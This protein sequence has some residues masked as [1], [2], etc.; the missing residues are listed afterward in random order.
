MRVLGLYCGHD[1]SAAVV[2]DGKVLIALEE[3]RLTGTKKQGGIP[4]RAIMY[5]CQALRCS[6]WD[7]DEVCVATPNLHSGRTHAEDTN[8]VLRMYPNARLVP[9]HEA[10]AALAYVWSGFP[11][12][13]VLTLDGGGADYFG[14]VNYC[15]GGHIERV[16]SLRKDE[17]EAF[18]MLYYYV[19][20]ALGFTP[21]RHEGKVMGLAASGRDLGLFDG[22]FWV[23]GEHIRSAGKREENIVFRRLNSMVAQYTRMSSP[24]SR[25]DIAAS[26]QAAFER[27]LLQ[28]VKGNTVGKLAV[29]GGC[30]ANVLTNM[31]IA[32]LVEDFYV[33]PPMMD[34]GLSIGAALSAFLWCHVGSASL[35]ARPRHMYFGL[36]PS[37]FLWC[38]VGSASLVARPKHMYFG[39]PQEPR[40]IWKP[41]SVAKYLSRGYV[42]GLFQGAMEFGPRALGNRTILADPRDKS[43]NKTLN[44]R[45]SRTEFMPFAP[46]ILEEYAPE[47]LEDYEVGK[48][49]AP[50]MTSCWKVKEEWVSKIPAVVHVDGTA[51]PQV[52][53]RDVN[54]F[55][56]DIVK[57]FY[58]MTGIPC[59]I[60]T[61][62]N[63]HEEPIICFEQEAQW[64]LKTGR[65]D[66]LVRG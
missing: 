11:E 4:A 46:V 48:A 39:L 29:S 30:F 42:I 41:E 18:G 15:S 28:W 21:N 58:D 17:D 1:A 35:V 44:E 52:I 50:F 59:L 45:L 49:N 55:Y 64:A 16:A 33:A 14:S 20:E 51:R 40:H 63:T 26:C 54:P 5:I 10:H 2:E 37:A 60:N 32:N 65:V 38:H 23:D 56:Y 43:I 34:D 25:D 62:F 7:F 22:L 6:P 53:S 36:P 3:E 61:S 57:A 66:V 24:L 19:T 9:H 8:S 12:C 31:K 13:T 27:T 47:I